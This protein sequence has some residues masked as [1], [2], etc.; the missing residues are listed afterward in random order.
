[1]MPD[2]TQHGYRAYPL[3]DHVAEKVCAMLERHGATNAPSTRYR[4]LVDLV[5]IVQAASIEAEP[6]SAALQSEARRRGVQF[7]EQFAVPDQV[8]WEDGY[9]AEASRSLLRTAQTLDE[10][11]AAVRLFLDPLLQGMA[12][13]TWHPHEALWTQ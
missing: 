3:V 7:P 12:N 4:D 1:M 6:Q 10:A 8:L 2:V 11:L 5:A 13:G 9:A